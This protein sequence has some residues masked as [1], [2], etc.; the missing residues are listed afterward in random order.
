MTTTLLI[1]ILL[2]IK[3][4]IC[5]FPLQTITYQFKAKGIY[6]H[7]VGVFH[8]LM[9]GV[10]TFLC[11]NWIA[12]QYAASLAMLDAVLHY[13]IDWAKIQ[14]DR[15]WHLHPSDSKVFWL[16]IMLDQILHQLTYILLTILSY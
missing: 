11:L 14:L 6:G 12:P 16:I 13:H 9:H 2:Q 4:T 10:G 7:W 8:A 3:H 1:F 5:D 15:R